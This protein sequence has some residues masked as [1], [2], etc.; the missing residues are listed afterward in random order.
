MDPTTTPTAPP[1]TPAPARP[2]TPSA[3]KLSLTDFVDLGTLQEIQDAFASVTRLSTTILDA[4]GH[5][6]T[7]P[8]DAVKRHQSD[9]VFE[10]LIDVDEELQPHPTV[11][12]RPGLDATAIGGTTG[13]GGFGS[14]G[15]AKQFQAPI[16]VEGQ[17]L[18]SIVIEPAGPSAEQLA[19][20]L[21]ELENL[22]DALELDDVQRREM[23][24]SA[25]IAFGTNRGAAI[26]FLY[27]MAN[28]IARLCFE[29]YHAQQR[30]EELSVLYKI[31][32]V[33]A[34]QSNLQE[35]LDI[36]ARSVAD[37]IKVKAVVIRL[38]EDTAEGPELRRAANT[39]LSEDYI[40]KGRLLVNRS[41]MMAAALRGET[42]YIA[43]MPTDPR[44]YYP[45]QA[46]AEGLV[47]ML[48]VGII[49]QGQPIGTLQLYTEQTRQFTQFE[50][51]L[52]R[53]ITQLLA[54]AI[55]KTRLD[56][57]RD[58]NQK[59][60]RQLHLAADVQRRML[61][62]K[63]P[64]IAGYDIA[65]RYVPSFEL[66]GDFYDFINLEHALGIG[67]GDVVGKGV[68]AS[69][70]MAGVRAS[71]R[72]F[73]Q[74]VYDLDEV[75]ARVNR[76]MCRDTLESEFA[77]LWYG[78]LDHDT[79]RLTYCNA[80][81]EPPLVVRGGKLHPL[82][83]GGMIVGVDRDQTYAK[84]IWDLKP[85]DMLL[86]Y[87]DGLPDAMNAEGQRFGRQRTEQLLLD[88]ADK[89]ANEA[90]NH[91]LWTVRQYTGPRRAT[92]DTTLILIKAQ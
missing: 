66:S 33:L 84:G 48:C 25:E 73:A 79:G 90:L 6:A 16:T 92:D 59:M 83:E 53:A 50:I 27:L 10:Q 3:P 69:L 49:Y 86:L 54:T 7:V 88:V 58:D 72:A 47:S 78:T 36:A 40:N 91:I 52:T 76:T 9:L 70:L 82:D 37:Q 15:G 5:P 67:I 61:P 71:L 89:S 46:R 85:G 31:S 23:L 55:E 44:V 39:G 20:R 29:Q 80:G 74:D 68:A 64:E 57:A 13:E 43:D 87:T 19:P 56:A 42:I 60:L 30:L 2:I 22:A 28:A 8:T 24:D 81:H 32:T 18:G 12:G 11:N 34:G 38:L 21:E 77:T 41:E 62:R 75:I 45:D 51:D 26:Q 35:T 14:G 1:H 63:M 17:M 65:A 4:D